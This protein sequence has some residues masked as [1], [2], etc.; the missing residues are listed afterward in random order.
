MFWNTVWSKCTSRH[1]ARPSPHHPPLIPPPEELF[2]GCVKHVT[3]RLTDG[4]SSGSRLATLRIPISPGLRAG[5]AFSL[6]AAAAGPSAAA[7]TLTV[8]VREA[9]HQVYRRV[10]DDLLAIVLVP[11]VVA[12]TGGRVSLKRLDGQLLEITLPEDPVVRPGAHV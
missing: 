8:V 11:L 5:T 2:T 6:R 12:L 7:A 1:P 10:G 3:V 4:S 9:L